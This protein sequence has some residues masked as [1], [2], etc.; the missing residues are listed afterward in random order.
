[1][2][3]SPDPYVPAWDL[4]PAG[5]DGHHHRRRLPWSVRQP[6]LPCAGVETSDL[7][8]AFEGAIL[9]FAIGDALGR[10]TEFISDLAE[11]RDK[12]GPQGVTDFEPDWHPAGAY[13]DDTQ[14]SLAVARALIRA[15]DRPLD[16]LMPVMAEEFV[17]WNRSPDNDRAPGTTCRAGCENLEAGVPWREAGVAESKGCGSA[18]RTAPIG[19]YYHDD[20]PRLV[21][22]ARASSLL[23]HGH[24]TALAAAT[25]TALLVAWAVH[26]DDPRDYPSRLQDAL[27]NMAGASEMQALIA[28]VPR[29]LAEPPDEVLVAGVLGEAWTGDEAVASALYCFCRS[30]EDYRRTVLT[31]HTFGRPPSCSAAASRVRRRCRPTA[32]R[33]GPW[34]RSRN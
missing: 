33:P 17:A 10:P 26:H 3:M 2:S 28:R 29:V 6:S 30:P 24:P 23:T 22:V 20:E 34:G 19:L 12:F 5:D 21:E 18:M 14:M 27:G 11:L 13:T 31:G 32:G 25:G 4:Q 8:S 9:G 1:M 7:K 16:E 15:G